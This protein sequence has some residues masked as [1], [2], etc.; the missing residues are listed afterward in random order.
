MISTNFEI[1]FDEDRQWFIVEF[2]QYISRDIDH[3]PR[4]M[5]LEIVELRYLLD[6]VIAST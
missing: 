2:T 4:L 1:S 5:L 6:Q 3:D